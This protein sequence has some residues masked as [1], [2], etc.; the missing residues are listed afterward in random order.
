MLQEHS[1]LWKVFSYGG[2]KAMALEEVGYEPCG[3]LLDYKEI[4]EDSRESWAHL[5]KSLI[6]FSWRGCPAG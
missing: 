2:L 4:Y 6:Y 1:Q 3:G 5:I